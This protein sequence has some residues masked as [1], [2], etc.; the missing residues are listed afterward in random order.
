MACLFQ[1][2][3]QPVLPLDNGN[4]IPQQSVLSPLVCSTTTCLPLDASVQEQLVLF[5]DFPVLYTS[6]WP[7]PLWI[8]L[9]C[10]QKFVYRGRAAPV[11]DGLQGICAA[12]ERV[13]EP[14][15]Y[16]EIEVVWIFFETPKQNENVSS[17]WTE[18]IFWLFVSRVPYWRAFRP[19]QSRDSNSAK[20]VL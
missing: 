6:P 9:C 16:L 15:Q 4:L 10:L 11:H 13:H 14:A 5:L 8:S 7:Y 18:N 12:P 1:L 3:E 17:V 19:A 20:L 2:P